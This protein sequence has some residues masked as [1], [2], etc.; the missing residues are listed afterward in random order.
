M[1]ANGLPTKASL[2]RLLSAV[3]TGAGQGGRIEAAYFSN[4]RAADMNAFADKQMSQNADS[5][6]DA[7]NLVTNNCASFCV[8]VLQSGGVDTPLVVDPRPVSAIQELQ[9]AA[10]WVITYDPKAKKIKVTCA[11]GE[12]DCAKPQ[13]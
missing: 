6:R 11:D 5:D 13:Q 1:G 12:S 4:D 7:Y 8:D 2:G 9:G 10:D 3:S